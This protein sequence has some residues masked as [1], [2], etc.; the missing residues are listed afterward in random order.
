MSR[1]KIRPPLI[2]AALLLSPPADLLA[3]DWPQWRGV[4]HDGKTAESLGEVSSLTPLWT[5]EVGIGFSSFSVVDGLVYTM[6][7]RDE[8]DT[9]WCL[10]AATGK[11]V[12][13]HTYPCALDPRYYEGGPGATPT[14][15]AGAVFT[16]SKKGHA[17]AF[18]PRTGAVLWQRDLVGDHGLKL[19]EW[20]F[21]GSP[22]VTGD[23]VVLNCGSAG[24][25]LDRQTG[26]TRWQSGPEATGYST[27]I[28][29][30]A[31]LGGAGVLALFLGTSMSGIEA[32]T[33]KERWRI[34]WKSLNATDPIMAG[35]DLLLSSIGGSAVMRLA[36][37]GTAKAVWESKDYRNY[38]NPP[39][40]IGD[41]LYG[42]DGTTH[43]PTA[44]VCV[45]WSTGKSLW[46]EEGHATGG[47][48]ATADLLVLC[49]Q[50]EIILARPTPEKLDIVLRETV[51]PGKCWTAPVFANGHLFARNAAGR[52]VCLKPEP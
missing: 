23:L 19:P 49:D 12:W 31:E 21:A 33:G 46:R 15:A 10:D 51:L 9:V 29:V 39:V 4:N 25:A 6:G 38:F 36:P 17:F 41:H 52:V 48:I 24:L 16:L 44:F 43:K 1:L 11:V 32:A 26:K 47:I 28:P 35:P 42:I 30:T 34:P 50:G 2:A 45:E 5:T 40:K 14:V 20:S 37:D 7:N 13:S 22:H 3:L 27:P 8:Q 18:H